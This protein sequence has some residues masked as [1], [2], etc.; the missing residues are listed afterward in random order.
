MKA[1]DLIRWAMQMT[2]QG[3]AA[4]VA[5]LRDAPL[6]QPTPGAKGGGGNHPFVDAGAPV[7]H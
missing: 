1:I 5:E 2:E 3:M 7:R 4:I 6:T